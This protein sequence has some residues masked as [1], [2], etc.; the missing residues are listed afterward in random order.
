M[1]KDNPKAFRRPDQPMKSTQS[2]R[3]RLDCITD[4]L[5][6][7]HRKLDRIEQQQ[8]KTMATLED[9]EREVTEM[10][11]SVD[12]AIAKI[13]ELIDRGQ[14]VDPARL[15]VIVDSLDAAQAAITAKLGPVEPPVEEPPVE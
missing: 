4:L 13:Q 11:A 7:V 3:D 6:G 1:R 8:E 10:R 9:V 15:Q 14:P 2:N 5:V 12:L